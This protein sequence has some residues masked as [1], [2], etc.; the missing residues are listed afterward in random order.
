MEQSRAVQSVSR[1][2]RWRYRSAVHAAQVLSSMGRS[3]AVRVPVGDRRPAERR[4]G[5][6]EIPRPR[7]S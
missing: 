6:A 3:D 4:A 1:V 2:D 5:R 7:A